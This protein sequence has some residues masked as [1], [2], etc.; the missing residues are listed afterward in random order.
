LQILWASLGCC[1]GESSTTSVPVDS[2]NQCEA[3]LSQEQPW[4]W[5]MGAAEV[6]ARLTLTESTEMCQWGSY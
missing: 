3:L 2:G 4:L 5:G 6:R 1:F